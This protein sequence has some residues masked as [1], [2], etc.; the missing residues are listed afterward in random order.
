MLYLVLYSIYI[1]LLCFSGCWS[2]CTCP[3]YII[4]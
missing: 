2:P 3:I 1:A 4:I